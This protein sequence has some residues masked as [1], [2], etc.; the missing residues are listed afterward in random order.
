M[1]LLI[2][3]DALKYPAPGTKVN[4]TAKPLEVFEDNALDN[5]RMEI[6][7]ELPPGAAKQA[8]EEFEAAWTDLHGSDQLPGL[9]GYG[10]DEIDEHQVMVEAF[11]NIQD[12]ILADAEKGNKIESKLALHL[13]GYQQRAKTLRSK[14]VEADGA[15]EKAKTELVTFRTL[16]VA[17]E[18]AIPKRLE[19]LREEVSF[20]SRREREAQELFRATREE[21]EGLSG[22]R[23]NGVH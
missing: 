20:L 8:A 4:G 12:A 6:S 15:L 17:E 1:A 14:I 21:L 19:A 23:V 9:A 5:A 2:A 3:N 22:G 11:D 13:G 7:L 18:A 16:Q 10:E